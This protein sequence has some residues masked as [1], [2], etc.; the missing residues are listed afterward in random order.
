ML[1]ASKGCINNSMVADKM[2]LRG[3]NISRTNS[4][5]AIWTPLETTYAICRWFRAGHDLLPGICFEKYD[6][7]NL[8]NL[9]KRCFRILDEC[10]KCL[11]TLVS[12]KKKY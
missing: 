1:E 3:I 9:I 8:S 2:D 7:E 6:L 11:Q 10:N 12:Q 4:S 5:Q